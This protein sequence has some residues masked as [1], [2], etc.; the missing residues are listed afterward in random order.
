MSLDRVLIIIR[1]EFIWL[2]SNKKILSNYILVPSL[3]LF[4]LIFIP[5]GDTNKKVSILI[6][7]PMTYFGVFL[8]SSLI[9]WEKERG[10]LLALLITPLRGLEWVFG[11]FFTSFIIS[12][13]FVLI[14]GWFLSGF[15][16]FF[17]LFSL[18]NTFL[19]GGTLCFIGIIIGLFSENLKEAGQYNFLVYLLFLGEEFFYLFLSPYAP[20]LP[21]YHISQLLINGESLPLLKKTYH[22]AFNLIFFLVSLGVANRYSLFYFTNNC[23]KRYSHQ[24]SILIVC[25]CFCLI[26]SGLIGS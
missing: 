9:I 7:F 14:G 21:D 19:V 6:L 13:L 22:T 24:L 25:F 3:V 11:I 2:F 17:D 5:E 8:S 10:T 4:L 18:L 16:I 12:L 1:K 26:F 23:E 20:W 15:D